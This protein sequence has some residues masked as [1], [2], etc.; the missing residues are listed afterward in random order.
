MVGL[1]DLSGC[2][3]VSVE[4]GGKLAVLQHSA[5]LVR[6][7]GAPIEPEGKMPGWAA[8]LTHE[9]RRG[10][11]LTRVHRCLAAPLSDADLQSACDDVRS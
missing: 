4:N 7:S 3:F 11:G 1:E 9:L 5:A 2:P 10:R 6:L 8:H